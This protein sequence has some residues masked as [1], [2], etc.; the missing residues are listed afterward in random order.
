MYSLF[1]YLDGCGNVQ[2]PDV[3]HNTLSVL[4]FDPTLYLKYHAVDV[5]ESMC[6]YWHCT[7]TACCQNMCTVHVIV[8]M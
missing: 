3:S 6:V 5:T 2:N 4:I 1:V 8:Y 7:C